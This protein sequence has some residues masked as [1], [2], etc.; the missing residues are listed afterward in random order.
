[1]SDSIQSQM[2]NI[3]RALAPA[4]VTPMLDNGL[5]DFI[6]HMAK[7]EFDEVASDLAAMLAIV[8]DLQL[9]VTKQER[10]IAKAFE[11]AHSVLVAHEATVTLSTTQPRRG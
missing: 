9:L 5:N 8:S 6:N 1:M 11:Y 2:D 4:I 3:L 10:S 7:G